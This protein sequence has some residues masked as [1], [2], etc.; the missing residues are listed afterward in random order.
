VAFT[1][2]L[3]QFFDTAGHAVVATFKTAA[4]A[5]IRTANVI[6][7]GATGNV[8]TFEGVEIEAPQPFLQCK[9]ADLAGINHTCKVTIAGITYRITNDLHDGTAT[10]IVLLKK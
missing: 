10:S 7:T 3:D 8:P 2:N 1:E 6:F 5:T 4:G 9:T